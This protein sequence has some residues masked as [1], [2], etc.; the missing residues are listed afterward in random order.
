[1]KHFVQKI[2]KCCQFRK[3]V[4]QSSR[5]LE[6][7]LICDILVATWIFLALVTCELRL[8]VKQMRD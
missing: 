5:K 7:V 3:L 8:I 1:M 6:S 4:L 2:G